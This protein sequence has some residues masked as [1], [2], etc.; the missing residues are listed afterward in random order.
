MGQYKKFI[1]FFWGDL[2]GKELKQFLYLSLGSFCLIGSHWLLKPLKE[3]L[4]LNMIG[5]KYLPDVKLYTMLSL[6]PLVMI[7]TR[8]V[9]HIA[10]QKLIYLFVGICSFICLLFGYYL[11][12]PVIG[13][14]NPATDPTRLIGWLFYIFSEVYLTVLVA[15]YWSFISDITSSESAKKGY[16]LVVFGSQTGGFIFSF[17]GK[18]FVYQTS[19]YATR[20][21]MVVLLAS[22]MILLTGVYIWFLLKLYP[23]LA[24]K[25]EEVMHQKKDQVGFFDG[26]KVFVT[27][28]YVAGIFGIIFFQEAVTALM[29]LQLSRVVEVVYQDHAIRTNFFFN[30]SIWVQVIACLFSLL[31]TSFMQRTFGTRLCLVGYPVGLLACAAGYFFYPSLWVLV[32]FMLIAKSMHFALNMPVKES[33][34]I[35][36]TQD[37]KY[38]SKAWIDMFGQRFSKFFGAQLSRFAGMSSSAVGGIVL[39]ALVLW[40]I[41]AERVGVTYDRAVENDEVIE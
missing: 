7:Y 19:A 39:G 32:A 11:L 3:S 28:P 26:I 36:T 18:A 9:D 10:K 38:K 25:E 40:G 24:E 31:G 41:L 22:G 6:I 13:V 8:M 23:E 15:L 29:G 5:G 4:F 35:P 20:V 34:Y 2:R 30:Y 16:G 12:D 17:V 14:A 21:P 33:L 27:H 1:R 37:I